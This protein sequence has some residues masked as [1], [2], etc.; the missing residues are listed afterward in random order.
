MYWR[1]QVALAHSPMHLECKLAIITR[2]AS[3]PLDG[4]WISRHLE[5]NP[6]D[7]YCFQVEAENGQGLVSLATSGRVYS[8][9]FLPTFGSIWDGSHTRDVD[10]VN[11]S[12]TASC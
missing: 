9:C 6:K 2:F 4:I 5:L 11:T 3:V 8:E 1:W 10:W 12:H 7:A